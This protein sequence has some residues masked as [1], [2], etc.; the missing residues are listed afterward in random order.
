M[1][2]S[3]RS[4]VTGVLAVS[5]IAIVVLAGCSSASLEDCPRSTR[6]DLSDVAADDAS[7][8]FRFPL[9]EIEPHPREAAFCEPSRPLPPDK[10]HA[11]EDYHRPAGTAV[12]AMADGEI[13]FSGP[14]GGYGWLLIIDHPQANLYSLYGHLSASRWRMEAGPV[15][16]GDLIAYLGDGWENGGSHEQPLVPHLHF[17]VRAGQ[18]SDYPGKGEW[19]WMAGWI[20]PCP[21]DLGWLQ[22]SVVMADQIIP[23]GGFENPSASFLEIWWVDLLIVAAALA[24]GGWWVAL[25]IRKRRP[26]VLLLIG[27]AIGFA[28]WV[29]NT[30]S[31]SLTIVMYALAAISI[32]TG[33]ILLALRLA[34]RDR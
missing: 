26:L 27:V 11:A 16:K 17:G 9:D 13:S 32:L 10:F 30:R 14:M 31:V 23:P 5:A 6:T 18:R 28:A 12:Y 21:R 34:N 4:G 33:F 7:L 19:R 20:R 3:A 8:P 15:T 1:I 24:G 25:G 29:L 2:T 22:P